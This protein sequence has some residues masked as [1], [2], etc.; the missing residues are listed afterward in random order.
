MT[1]RVTFMERT[2][3]AGEPSE[4]P[5]D[6]A[7]IDVPEGVV[8]GKTFVERTEASGLH[9]ED[10]LE[11]DDDFLSA[12]SETWD[13]EIAE[14]RD[15]EFIAALQNSQMVMEYVPLDEEPSAA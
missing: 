13:Y 14:D 9:S 3:A 8:L 1:Y 10:R 12:G 5:A 7:A 4:A 11:E 15:E 6:Y 2:D